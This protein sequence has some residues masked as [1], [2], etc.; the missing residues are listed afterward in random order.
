[1]PELPEVET[2]RRGLEP[3]LK[4]RRLAAVQV[5]RADL[6]QPFPPHLARDLEGRRVV[7]LARRA[8]Y[9]LLHLDDGY[10]LLIHLGMSGRM[11]VEPAGQSLGRHD[12]LV[13]A[14]D[15]GQ[16]IVFTDPRRFGRIDRVKESAL[17]GH[18]LLVGLGPEPLDP[19]FDA[20]ALSQALAGSRAPLK[21]ALMD[22]RRI[23]GIGNIYASEALFRAR[24]APDRP[25]GGLAKGECRR[26]A[27]AIKTVLTQAI[28][29]GGSTLRDHVRPDGELGYF[30]HRFQVYDRA[31]QPCPRCKR[32]RIL[33][34]V[35]A[36]RA[37]YHCP[38]CQT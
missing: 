7:R 10:V 35:Q 3:A 16:A 12:H 30:Q 17:A 37:T 31:G 8:K 25:A 4:G 11:R 13:L 32:T 26:L 18:P 22:Q 24:L 29:A 5:R 36:G 20:A 21:T 38:H 9:L 27:G 15:R 1:M 6:R 33:R 34:H 19:A 28:A 14:T 2:V 23:A